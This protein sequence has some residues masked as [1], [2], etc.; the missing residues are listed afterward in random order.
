MADSDLGTATIVYDHPDEGTV[1]ETVQNE[2]IAYFQD[3][4]ILKR[5]ED[6]DG[7]DVV[8]RIPIQR[9]HYVDRSV[10]TFEDEIGSVRKQVENVASDLRSKLLGD[11]DEREH[12]TGEPV[13]I[14]V[15]DESTDDG[16]ETAGSTER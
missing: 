1:E 7:N 14:D 6:D 3:H 4:W 8:R 10:D 15:T 16:D 5:D 9:V 11:R 12:R 13:Q 2:H